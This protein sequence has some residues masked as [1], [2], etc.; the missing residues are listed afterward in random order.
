VDFFDNTAL[1]ASDETPTARIVGGGALA[2]D[3]DGVVV[4]SSE[5]GLVHWVPAG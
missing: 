2:A 4:G 3:G 1:G 5:S